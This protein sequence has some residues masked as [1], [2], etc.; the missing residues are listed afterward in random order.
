MAETPNVTARVTGVKITRGIK[1]Q[2][3]GYKR[4][5]IKKREERKKGKG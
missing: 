2:Q 3:P 4:V 5:Q 1:W